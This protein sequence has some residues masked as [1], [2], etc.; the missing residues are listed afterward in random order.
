MLTLKILWKSIKNVLRKSVIF[1]YW[2]NFTIRQ[3][4][5][6]NMQQTMIIED[7]IKDEKLQYDINKEAPKISAW[8]S[9]KID[10]YDCL[11][12]EEILSFNQKQ[13]IEQTKF[14]C[15]PL[16]KPFRK[17]TKKIKEK[18]KSKQLK[19]IIPRSI[20]KWLIVIK[21]KRNNLRIFIT[22]DFMK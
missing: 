4:F 15:S 16:G 12:G 6:I 21:E 7:Q 20:W 18:N 17:Q 22:K 13:I 1:R 8:S 10:K 5:R 19:E 3:S 11:T 14:T 2:Y 9:G